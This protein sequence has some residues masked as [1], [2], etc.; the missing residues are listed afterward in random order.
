[1]QNLYLVWKLVSVNLRPLHQK[2]S[3]TNLPVL[4]FNYTE[5]CVTQLDVLLSEINFRFNTIRCAFNRTPI[6]YILNL[7]GCEDVRALILKIV[8]FKRKC[9]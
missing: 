2:N 9:F 7:L 5:Q 6:Y 8:E 1:M 3:Y 4:I